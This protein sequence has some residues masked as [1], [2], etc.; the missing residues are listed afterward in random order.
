M[1]WLLFLFLFLFLF[2]NIAA[3]DDVAAMFYGALLNLIDL[4]L[5]WFARLLL[6]LQIAVGLLLLLLF[7]TKGR[8]PRKEESFTPGSLSIRINL[9]RRSK[10][11]VINGWKIEE[12]DREPLLGEYKFI[13]SL[14]W[15]LTIL[16]QRCFLS[17]MFRFGFFVDWNSLSQCT[18]TKLTK[19]VADDDDY[20]PFNN[21]YLYGA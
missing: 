18:I 17:F 10:S 11:N 5:I 16:V 9:K 21:P 6:G 19:T 15:T 14:L 13:S 20:D 1:W 3:N 2:E 7:R 4:S 12:E 8:T